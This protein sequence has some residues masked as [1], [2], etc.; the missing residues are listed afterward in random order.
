[1]PPSILRIP[2][3]G[4]SFRHSRGDYGT[5]RNNHKTFHRFLGTIFL[6]EIGSPHV[7]ENQQLA[8]GKIPKSWKNAKKSAK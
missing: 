6:G 2:R 3:S 8:S 7:T 1:L 4:L 5:S